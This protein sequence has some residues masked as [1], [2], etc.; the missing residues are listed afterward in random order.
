MT[1]PQLSIDRQ[2][3]NSP[4]DEGISWFD[5]DTGCTVVVSTPAA[6]Q[7]LWAEFVDGA[8]RSYHR[9]GIESALDMDALT[10]EANT[11]LFHAVVNDSGAVMG[12]IRAKGPLDSP[13]ESHAIVEWDGRPGLRTVRKMLTDRL[14]FGVVEM[15]TA[16]MSDDPD[17]SRGISNTLARSPFTTMVLLDAQFVVATAG[18]HVLNRWRTSG[19]VVAKVPATPYPDDRY[20]TKMMWWDRSTFANNADAEQVSKIF[21]ELAIVAR[22]LDHVGARALGSGL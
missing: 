11:Q 6:D 20:R 22:Q 7:A 4:L 17:R 19:G 18:A 2:V 9:H 3:Y 12:G 14:P 15:K 1:V 16:W 10:D 5:S 8:A 13:E 21:N